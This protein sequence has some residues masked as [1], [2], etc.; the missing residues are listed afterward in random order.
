M[1]IRIGLMLLTLFLSIHVF[2]QESRMM[3]NKG[4]E[5]RHAVD[6][7]C[8][9]ATVPGCVHL[10]QL[11]NKI[12][13]DPFFRENEKDLQWIEEQDW[14]Y[15][16]QF[17]IT[18]NQLLSSDIE[19]VFEGLDTYATLIL[20][21]V[22][23]AETN[24]MFRTWKFSVKNFLKPG[25]NTLEITFVSA[26][27][28]G[29]QLAKL[30]PYTLPG[31]E[32]VFTRKAAYQYGW[33]WGPRYVTC[34]I[35]R[36]VYLHFI[37]GP[38]FKDIY[39]K[40]DKIT[41]KKAE[42]IVNCAIQSDK[43][44]KVLLSIMGASQYRFAM[45]TLLEIK[46]GLNAV[47]IPM[48]IDHPKR[49]LEYR[50]NNNQI[51]DLTSFHLELKKGSDILSKKDIITGLRSL[52]LIHE[53]DSIGNSF[54]FKVNGKPLFIRGA[55]YIPPDN[56][57]SRP[58][59][60]YYRK[61]IEDA[62][63]SNINM[64]R[65]W[66]G[67]N[68]ESDYFYDL[69][70]AYGILVWQDFMFACAMYPGDT[71][72]LNN[73]S[74]EARDIITRLR[75]HPCLALWCG[76]NEI[77]E[78]W[79]NWGWQLQYHYSAGDSARIWQ[80]YL[81]IFEKILPETVR[82]LDPGRAYW[83]SSPSIGWGHKE[84]MLSG[85]SHYWG[86]WWGMEPFETYEKKVP[87]FM[88]E[89]GFQGFPDINTI[90][91]FTDPQDR[92]LGSS[93]LKSHQK[94]PTGFET[95]QTYMEREF[96]APSSL[97]DYIY[98]SQVLQAEGIRMAIQAQR[99]AKPRCMGTLYW[100]YNDC[101]PVVSWSGRDWYGRWKALQYAVKQAYEPFIISIYTDSL[102]KTGVYLINDKDENI[103]GKLDIS[104]VDT[105][106]NELYST[107]FKRLI[108][109]TT[110]NTFIPLDEKEFEQV[111]WKNCRENSMILAVF[112]DI[113]NNKYYCHYFYPG[114]KTQSLPGDLTVKTEPFSIRIADSP[115][116]SEFLTYFIHIKANKLV[117]NIWLQVEGPDA[118]FS[119]NYFDLLP[120]EEKTVE[121]SPADISKP[122]DFTTFKIKSLTY[123][124]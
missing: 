57:M 66:G 111:I 3:L 44:E 112:T 92:F 33:D 40:Q 25:T 60:A 74:A 119:D 34:G 123:G 13:P 63:A 27:N 22:I 78:G 87:R 70:D 89:F 122:L 6:T 118:K 79:H 14:V 5:F 100:Q 15:K 99:R 68:Y 41:A 29:K 69:C 85:D 75:N 96:K 47:K 20:N 39:I 90:N 37:T 102:G 94:H 107:T 117:R 72:F 105:S 64:L 103:E 83:P 38:V 12:I 54:Y 120:G 52:E 11:A 91:A 101:W 9:P 32:K 73:V 16:T 46:K 30:L 113:Y 56:F 59:S 80:D 10:D 4:W 109:S 50:V 115:N 36:P 81:E 53:K 24:N 8:Y 42:V 124:R 104:V 7:D 65:V 61:M 110:K 17:E 97:K 77:D 98:V 116:R 93:M 2:S 62:K 58:D 45:D 71:A 18:D 21:Q 82:A 51:H 86:V 67:G 1:K 19:L 121:C 114:R 55:N 23:L 108:V 84:S 95:I 106:M 88:S 28:K 26:V 43:E 49:W 31:D 35:W 48:V 76:N